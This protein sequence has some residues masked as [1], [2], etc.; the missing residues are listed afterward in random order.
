[1]IF[2]L[3]FALTLYDRRSPVFLFRLFLKKVDGRWGIRTL[4]LRLARAAIYQLI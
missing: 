3:F 1:M 4:G 2:Y